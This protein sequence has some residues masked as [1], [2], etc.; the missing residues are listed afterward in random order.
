VQA[1]LLTMIHG[2]ALLLVFGDETPRVQ[3]AAAFTICAVPA[4]LAQL[5]GLAVLQ[6]Q[7]RFRAFNLC[8]LAPAVLYALSAFA[9]F[10]AGKGTLLV[11]TACYVGALLG[12][13]VASVIALR[14]LG[15]SPARARP[16]ALKQMIKFGAKGFLGSASPTDGFGLDQAVVGL[17]LSSSALGLYVVG[18]A[19][20]NLPRFVAQSIGMVAYPNVA[21]R[22]DPGDARRTLWR[23]F[24]LGL[25]ICLAIV[26]GLELTVGW[27]LPLLFGRSFS[28][29]VEI[30][31]ILLVSAMLL[32]ARRVLSDAARG[33]GQATLGTIAEVASWVALFPAM[34]LLVPAFGVEGVAAALAISS[35]SGLAAIVIG[36][37]RTPVESRRRSSPL[38]SA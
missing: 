29:A 6:G 10:L 14:G 36:L 8:R 24:W 1:L 5:Y 32:S 21:A 2:V 37:I 18:L 11:I 7:Q 30:T 25:S 27:L 13:G 17:F 3:L 22:A 15:A 19:F 16:P 23:F 12:G 35:G 38:S 31:R 28:G 9:V 26:A 4:M 33:A 34:A 20:T